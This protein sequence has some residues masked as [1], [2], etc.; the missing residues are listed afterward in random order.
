M[1]REEIEFLAAAVVILTFVFIAFWGRKKFKAIEE[2][3]KR[4][5]EEYTDKANDLLEKIKQAQEK[6]KKKDE[7][8]E[9]CKKCKVCI[10]KETE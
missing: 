4:T 1:S 8:V 7:S 2:S 9:D 6:S 5:I 10:N 3:K